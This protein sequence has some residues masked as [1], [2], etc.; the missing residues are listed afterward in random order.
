[1]PLLDELARLHVGERDDDLRNDL[2]VARQL[3]ELGRIVPHPRC[4]GF[5]QRIGGRCPVLVEVSH[6]TLPWATKHA[7]ARESGTSR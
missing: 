4:E 6:G 5:E 1:V 3:G 2:V 7:P